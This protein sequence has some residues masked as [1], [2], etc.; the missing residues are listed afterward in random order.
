M[1][2][3]T[4]SYKDIFKEQEKNLEQYKNSYIHNAKL[5]AFDDFFRLGFPT[6]RHEAWKY[7]NVAAFTRASLNPLFF[8]QVHLDIK[9]SDFR[10]YDHIKA[11]KL[12]VVNGSF[13]KHLSEIHENPDDVSIMSVS[14]AIT[15]GDPCFARHFNSLAQ[16]SQDHFTALNTSM[17]GDGIL[18]HVK[19]NVQCQYPIIWY[20]ISKDNSDCI[21]NPRNLI[22]LD[23]GAKAEI[24][25]D[26]QGLT[27]GDYFINAVTEIILS[28][29]ATLDMT[30]IQ[31]ETSHGLHYVSTK[32]ISQKK[33]SVFN[34]TN[35][36]LSGKLIRNNLRSIL[37]EENIECNIRG[38]YYGKDHDTIDN[39]FLVEHKAENC[40][41]NQLV[42]G[43]LKDESNGIFTGKIY[44]HP[45]AN[46]TNA[47]QKNNNLLLSES[48]TM[49]S[50]PQLEIYAD[51][52]KC[53]HG[54]TNGQIDENAK[55]YLMSRGLKEDT[56]LSF[57][58]YAFVA[59]VFGFIK[60]Q[61]IRD[62]LDEVF[63][64]KL[65]LVQI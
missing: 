14:E 36:S 50:R 11:N 42:K 23:K 43:I 46:K 58:Q 18:I 2:T 38:L 31:N 19:K 29:N 24:I 12:V 3:S 7:T 64:Y 5:D 32:E 44:V 1:N 4:Y 57:I 39:N 27:E 16:N 62:Y 20:F 52:V 51:D 22:I 33:N 13:Q 65:G 15:G 35:I 6:R 53:S 34:F 8:P 54:A 37:S 47:Y 9:K 28:E 55:Y 21:I 45:G 40:V 30:S 59:E 41:S 56:A 48:A 61:G 49:N 26:H 60:N 25:K 10:Y 63:R 17:F